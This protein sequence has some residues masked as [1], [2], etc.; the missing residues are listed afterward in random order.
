MCICIYTYIFKDKFS[1]SSLHQLA[2][3]F[4]DLFYP[5]GDGSLLANI[6]HLKLFPYMGI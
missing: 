1:E 3:T 6:S 5:V 4:S 2:L